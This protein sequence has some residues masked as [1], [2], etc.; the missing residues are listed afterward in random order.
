MV[1][2]PIK[3]CQ[4]WA[5]IPVPNIFPRLFS[6]FFPNLGWE[7]GFP[8]PFP[9]QK[10]GKNVFHSHSQSQNLG[11]LFSS[12]RPTGP[13]RS[14]SRDVRMYACMSVPFRVVYFEAY[15]APTSRSRMSKIF[16]DSES[17]GKSAGKKWSQNWTFLL[18]S[19]LKSPRKKKFFFVCWFCLTKHGGNHASQ[20]IRDLWSKGISLI[21]A[22]L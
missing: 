4:A 17:L 5:G 1:Y 20:W 10:V 16:R 11:T 21:L 18:G 8:F 7:H 2:W 9:I 22:Y 19:G 14:S 15:F 3:I 12:N 6:Q 13:I